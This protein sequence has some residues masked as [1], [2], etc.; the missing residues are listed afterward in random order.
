[1]QKSYI[2]LCI[3]GLL[4]V[5]IARADQGFSGSTSGFLTSLVPDPPTLQSPIN[6]AIIS[7]DSTSIS[8]LSEMHTS[9]YH[10]QISTSSSF[11]TLSTDEDGLSDT[12]FSILALENDSTYYWR[13]GASNMAGD[14]PFS[15]IWTFMTYSLSA[16]QH[17]TQ[18]IPEHFALLPAYPNPFNPSTMIIYHLPESA[19]ISIVIYNSIGQSIRLLMSGS[20]PAGEY[21][22][23][24]DGNNDRGESMASGVYICHLNAGNRTLSQKIL[25]MR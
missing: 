4:V 11:S 9:T 17:A 24:W 7:P 16:I 1:M 8:W 14:G 5:H 18:I 23:V 21:G 19:D 13:V 6:Q 10:L 2:L 20:Q 15:E 12:L 3:S 25:L 22:A